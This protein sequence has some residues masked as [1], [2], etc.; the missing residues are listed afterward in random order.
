M[1]LTHA[2]FNPKHPLETRER[3]RERGIGEAYIHSNPHP[4]SRLVSL[5]LVSPTIYTHNLSFTRKCRKSK[6][7]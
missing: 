4:S 1:L 6:K 3:E 5:R 2:C 7:N